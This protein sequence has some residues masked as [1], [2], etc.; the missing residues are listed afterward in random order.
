[1]KAIILVGGEGTRLR[2]LTHKIPKALVPIRDKTL[3]EHV[4]DILRKF[5]VKE[6]ILSVAYKKEMV[7][8]KFG[9]GKDLGLEISY[10]EEPSPLG[11][12]GPL[13]ILNQQNS[14]L[15]ETFFMINGDN[16]FDLDLKEMLEF[17]KRNN[18]AATIALSRVED[19]RSFGVAVM[20]DDKITEFVE[21]PQV[22][23]SNYINSGYYIM[24]PEV[25]E[26]IKGKEKAM[27][28]KDIF[29]VLAEQGKLF[30]YRSDNLWFDT[31][32]P[33][34]YDQVKKEWKLS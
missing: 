8:E 10:V 34:R 6:I 32:T 13:I 23:P 5:R 18:A 24:E 22:P 3:T 9:E 31:G 7:R 2:P 28:E 30:G 12:A 29:P 33:E 14:P 20:E 17:H 1:M 15:T 25:F 21:K 27:I 19:P 16:L 11:T 26:I 4:F